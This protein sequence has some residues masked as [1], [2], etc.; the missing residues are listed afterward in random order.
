MSN[1]KGR[2]HRVA[3]RNNPRMSRY[4]VECGA[5]GCSTVETVR[6]PA[7]ATARGW[8]RETQHGYGWICPGCQTGEPLPVPQ[9]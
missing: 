5:H 3:F 8:Y 9:D 6:D 4:V 2:L 7:D 1:K